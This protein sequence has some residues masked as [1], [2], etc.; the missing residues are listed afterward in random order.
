MYSIFL[1]E[2]ECIYYTV[3]CF[4]LFLSNMN[5]ELN[6]QTVLLQTI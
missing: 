3:K 2:P 1:N 4:H 5:I 6:N